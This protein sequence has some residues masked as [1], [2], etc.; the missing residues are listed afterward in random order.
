MP[1]Y[2]TRVANECVGCCRPLLILI[3]DSI[4]V[5]VYEYIYAEIKTC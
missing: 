1:M 5:Y 4:Y 3:A 2:K